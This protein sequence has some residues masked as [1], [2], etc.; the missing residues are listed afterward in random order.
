M[1]ATQVK[2]VGRM[3]AKS[4]A[5]SYRRILSCGSGETIR[6]APGGRGQRCRDAATL[7]RRAWRGAAAAAR[8]IQPGQPL[9]QLIAEAVRSQAGAVEAEP[10]GE[11]AEDGLG[12]GEGEECGVIVGVAGGESA[13]RGRV[14]L[15]ALDRAGVARVCQRKALVRT[16]GGRHKAQSLREI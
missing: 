11:H 1:H 5:L 12:V 14:R 16:T 7:L 15:G 2:V 13:D 9:A 6:R 10:E 8:I 4:T 3:I